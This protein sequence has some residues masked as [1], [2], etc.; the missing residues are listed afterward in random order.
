[1]IAAARIPWPSPVQSLTWG[2][3][4]RFGSPHRNGRAVPASVVPGR[5]MATPGDLRLN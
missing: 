2:R 3:P 4:S 5:K 1:M